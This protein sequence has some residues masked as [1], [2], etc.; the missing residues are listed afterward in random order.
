MNYIIF[1]DQITEH[2]FNRVGGKNA[3]LGHM[4]QALGS[5]EIKIPM[6]FAVTVDAYRRHLEFHQLNHALQELLT[7]FHSDINNS[8]ALSEQIRQLIT[9]YPLPTDV[10]EEVSNAYNKLCSLYRSDDLD[11][12]VR[13]S[14]TAEDLPGASFAGQQESYLNISGIAELLDACLHGMASLF[15][16]RAM[17]YR[18]EHGFDDM[19]VGISIGVQKMVRSDLASAGVAFTLEPES[20]FENLVVING[21][22]G[23]GEALVQG[24]VTPDEWYVFKP[25]IEKEQPII[26]KTLGNKDCLIV[27]GQQG[28]TVQ[29]KTS[30]KQHAAFCLDDSEV[31][32]LAKMAL[33][34]EN[35][36]SHRAG[37]HTP[38]DIE[39]AK[40][41]NDGQMY[42]VQA[43]P[44]TVYTKRKSNVLIQT[45]CNRN[46]A[47]ILAK[48]QAI[49][50]GVASGKI[51]IVTSFSDRVLFSPGDILVTSMTDPDWVPLMKMASGIIT[52]RG[53]RT[54]HAAIVARELSL[55]A[56][57]G[58]ENAT[59]IFNNGQ[60]VTLDCSN[61]EEGIIIEGIA[62][63]TQQ[64]I[65]LKQAQSTTPVM[66]ITANPQQ[67]FILQRLPVQGVGLARMEFI[68]SQLIGVH[69]LAIVNP[70]T[71]NQTDRAAINELMKGYSDPAV[72]FKEKLS[73]GIAQIAAAFYPREV[74]VRL[75][76]LK[77]NEY[78]NLIGGNYFEPEEENPMLGYR[79]AF[80]YRHP[81]YQPAFQLE[82]E[83]LKLVRN[84]MGLQNVILMIPFVRTPH[85]LKE[86]IDL[87]ASYGLKRG[88]NGLKIYM[89][90]EIPTNVILLEHYAAFVDGFSIGSN[91]LTQLTL[92]V[93]R[94]S[95]LLTREFDERDEAVQILIKTAIEKAKA[96]GKPI[97]ICGQAPSDFPAFAQQLRE[98]GIATISLNPDAV[99][100]F[101]KRD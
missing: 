96:V 61:G 101:L 32:Q 6:G 53:G 51:C 100:K 14:A 29:T 70:E 13:S 39:W 72:W 89:M 58:V 3:S 26:K 77:T 94:D 71:I 43:R 8:H 46:G 52:E 86:V 33:T 95:A 54:C 82:C 31:I 84:A 9:N 98:W 79:G 35:Y 48:G 42:I 49:G 81:E 23:L 99:I 92:G 74:I 11:V 56:I 5:Q 4:V 20:G 76:D 38:M 12:A 22:W 45:T 93:D 59:Q 88:E 85:E 64:E 34:I 68:L 28:R 44:E 40:D 55:P 67:A 57:V 78:R 80:R 2:D 16:E 65:V 25:I 63:C 91:D 21:S 27:Y 50:G 1:F 60:M 97:G 7:Q 15:T 73:Q 37:T 87:M 47:K 24:T 66:I 17:I 41:G 90:V 18:K 62:E 69:P 30:D 10:A 19:S 36:F 75:S 83:A